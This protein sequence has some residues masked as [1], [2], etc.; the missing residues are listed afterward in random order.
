[1]AGQQ[2]VLECS[3]AVVSRAEPSV[4]WKSQGHLGQGSL[5]HLRLSPLP[6]SICW[7]HP[8]HE[9]PRSLQAQPDPFH[10][11]RAGLW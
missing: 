8:G 6:N 7:H 1:M 9:L 11:P 3:N 4:Q 10:S 2:G 5:A